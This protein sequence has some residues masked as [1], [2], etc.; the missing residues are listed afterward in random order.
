M[1]MVLV[2]YGEGFL[3][4]DG[5]ILGMEFVFFVGLRGCCLEKCCVVYVMERFC[6]LWFL[7]Y[8][9]RLFEGLF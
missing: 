9:G 5:D 7:L 2:I 1:V 8:K 4:L 3:E 6:I